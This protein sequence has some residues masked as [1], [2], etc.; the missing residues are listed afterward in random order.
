ML[1]CIAVLEQPLRRRLAQA[2][3]VSLALQPCIRDIW[4]DHVLYVGESVSG[5]VDFGAMAVDTVI[6]DLAR[7]L[8]SLVADD[9]QRWRTGIEVYQ[10]WMPLEAPEL[11]LLAAFDRAN[12]ILG[13]LN[14]IRWLF[15]EDRRF[16]NRTGVA[17][18][19]SEIRSRLRCWVE[20]GAH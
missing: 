20:E 2:S 10:R 3:Q 12:G 6:G 17:Q 4:H 11:E 16:E 9:R 13:G 8:G 19:I 15:L 18:R 14:W 1:R 7:L 5:I